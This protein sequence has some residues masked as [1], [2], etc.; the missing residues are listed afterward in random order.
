MII[1]VLCL[2]FLVKLNRVSHRPTESELSRNSL[3][4]FTV[5]K[6]LTLVPRIV[7]DFLAHF[8]LGTYHF[9]CLEMSRWPINKTVQRY[10]YCY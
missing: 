5:K 8:F 4:E 9:N 6:K 3:W 2:L 10:E 1:S 7:S